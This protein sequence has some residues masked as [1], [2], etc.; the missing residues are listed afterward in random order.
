MTKRFVLHVGT[1]MQQG[2]PI[3]RTTLELPEM[4]WKLW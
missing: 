2:G 4:A 1:V 3:R